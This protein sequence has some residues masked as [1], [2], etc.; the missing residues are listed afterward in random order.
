MQ[1]YLYSTIG[2][3]AIPVHLIINYRVMFSP[4]SSSVLKASKKYRLLII[5]IFTYYITDT[6]W[7]ILAGLHWT[8]ALFFDTT[9]Y[10]TAMSSAI[11]CFYRY[12]VDYLELWDFRARI[13]NYFGISFFL[14]ENIFL[15]INFFYPCFFWF[16]EKGAYIAGPVRYI[17]LWVQI[18]MF[19]FSTVVTAI[20][21]FR[22]KGTA[23]RPHLA[24]FLFSLTML[25]AIVFQEKYPLLP[26]Y[27]I[28]CMFGS[29]LL[30][31][32]IAGDEHVEFQ[33]MLISE[34]SK[35]ENLFNQLSNYKRAVLSDALISL[36]ANLSQNELFYGVWKDDKG[37]LV[38]LKDILGIEPPC[39]YDEYIRMWN[40]KFVRTRDSDTFSGSTDRQHLLTTYLSGISEVTFDYEA[41]T[42]NGRDAWLRRSIC[43][44]MN[45]DGDI[46][47]FT[48]VKDVSSIVE[49][50]KREENYVR[51]LEKAK[52]SAESASRAKSTF[53]FNMSH[54]IRT[55]MNA[56]I[57][58]TEIAEKHID[59]KERVIDALDKVKTSS[60][61]LLS[62]VNDVLDMSRI[63]SG[64]VKVNE[65][66]VFFDTAKDNLFSILNGSAEA[67]SI[68]FTSLLSPDIKH[69][70]IYTDRLLTMRVLT[71][72]ISN[73]VKYTNPGGKITLFA[74]EIPSGREGFARFRYTITDNGIGM[75]QDFLSRIYEPFSR[76]ESAT[77]SGVIG[78]GLGMSITKTLVELMGGIISIESELNVGTKVIM[79]FDYRIAEP[80]SP[81]N[82][83]HDTTALNLAGKRVLLV[84]DNKF[85][86]EI[87]TEILEDEGM[88]LDFAED[89][90]I[91]VEKMK[92]AADGQYDLLLMDIQMPHMN[93]YDA[94]RA[95]RALPGSY[96]KNVP[97][98]A[99]T[100]NA[101][102]EDKQNAFAAG[103]NGHLSKPVKVATLIHTLSDIFSNK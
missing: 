80:V 6:L 94:T 71:N 52:I 87:A 53:L 14:L 27:A 89:G 42:I 23:R 40:Q 17:A 63:E 54:D 92:N 97:I 78:T 36:E 74:E 11:V 26:Y 51:E 56:I 100:A 3:I 24:I 58:F 79:E 64:T 75:S 57:G 98:I 43:M 45:Q 91:A 59:D 16:D 44:T 70:W 28:G 4:S 66:P 69:H 102:D 8:K 22:S 67:K 37:V 35:L 20:E 96:P 25:V 95:I 32:F 34:K 83:V 77:K 48:S 30:H 60:E 46:I 50:A 13:F 47:A 86:R 5:A 9:F 33:K 61:H 10:Y 93:G 72:I 103:M 90:D 101:F 21:A 99:M 39:S 49:Q 55:P 7:G 76:A 62:L 12:I 65:E 19:A 29:L 88:I 82:E 84:E 15:I 18:A 68:S 1:D 85:N 31:V 41:K 38:P 81:K 2:L 73:S